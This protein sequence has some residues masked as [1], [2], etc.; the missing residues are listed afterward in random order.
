MKTTLPIEKLKP[1]KARHIFK[2]FLCVL[3][4]VGLLNGFA[5]WFLKDHTLNVGYLLTTKKWKLLIDTQKPVDWLIL[6]D[7]SGNAAVMPEVFHRKFGGSS[8]NLCTVG[9]LSALNDVWMLETYLKRFGPPKGVLIVHSAES[10]YRETNQALLAQIPLPWGFWERF[11]PPIQLIPQKTF[12]LF[13]D[14]YFPLYSHNETLSNVFQ[15]RWGSIVHSFRMEP[16][17]FVAHFANPNEVEWSTQVILQQMNKRPFQV[18]D[19]N[20]KAMRKLLALTRQYGFD[21]YLVNGPVYESLYQNPDFKKY[22]SG[23]QQ[24]FTQMASS[25]P[26]FYYNPDPALFHKEEM[27]NAFHVVPA[28]ARPYSEKVCDWI[29]KASARM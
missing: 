6:G 2:L 18:S 15:F 13:L 1:A 11:D 14:R 16:D 4:M 17:G 7:S 26:H 29:A 28:A 5:I 21:L 10:W 8:L 23:M 27:A 19:V 9:W 3:L 25:N 12:E 22:F 24:K 20:E